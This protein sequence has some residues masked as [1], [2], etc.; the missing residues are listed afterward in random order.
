[1]DTSF[2]KGDIVFVQLSGNSSHFGR[3]RLQWKNNGGGWNYVPGDALF[4]SAQAASQADNINEINELG[5]DNT[6]NIEVFSNYK[7]NSPLDHTFIEACLNEDCSSIAS[8]DSV[9][10]VDQLTATPNVISD[11][12]Q[13]GSDDLFTDYRREFGNRDLTSW[14]RSPYLSGNQKNRVGFSAQF[15]MN[16]LQD[17]YAEPFEE[18]R[19]RLGNPNS[20]LINRNILSMDE[21]RSLTIPI[22]DA[23]PSL[24]IENS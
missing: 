22:N 5:K 9:S 23:S 20:T 4:L 15:E 18:I 3:S 11:S 12:G 10:N 7:I 1:M 17:I 14:K 16:V 6:R 24:S 21:G 19:L 2:K 13:Q 8:Q